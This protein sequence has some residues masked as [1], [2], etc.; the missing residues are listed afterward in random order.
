MS[1]ASAGPLRTHRSL[2]QTETPPDYAMIRKLS[3]HHY[4]TVA[5]ALNFGALLL[6]ALLGHAQQQN[7]EQGSM[8]GM[9]MSG[10]GD[11]S[12]TGP[13]M[14]VMAG[15]RLENWQGIRPCR[16]IWQ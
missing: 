9:D 10:M 1:S 12:D 14:A 6:T 16:E 7:P 3:A 2:I 11:M 15:H 5:L 4:G 8:P 13:S